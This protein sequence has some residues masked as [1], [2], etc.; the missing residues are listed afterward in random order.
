MQ[1]LDKF[2]NEMNLS[3]KNLYVGHRYVPKIFGEWD[4]TQSYEALSIVQYQGTSY[5]SRQTVPV[6]IEITNEEFWALTGNYNAQIEQYRKDVENVQKNVSDSLNNVSLTLEQ[7]EN[8]INQLMKESIVI[9]VTNPPADLLPY[10]ESETVTEN[11]NRLNKIFDYVKLKTY[12]ESSQGTNLYIGQ[13]YTVYF[14]MTE[15][16]IDNT[17]NVKGSYVA[18]LGNKTIIRT[19]TQEFDVFKT[20]GND[21]WQ[22]TIDDFQFDKTGR[23][24]VQ[25]N[26]NLEGGYTYFTRN[27]LFGTKGEAIKITK[28]SSIGYIA[29]NTFIQPEIVL[30]FDKVDRMYFEKNWIS[31]NRKS[32]SQSAS[33]IARSM[34]LMTSGNLWVPYPVTDAATV[35]ETAYINA[36]CTVM[37]DNDHYGGE[38]GSKTIINVFNNYSNLTDTGG[39]PMLISII[40][41]PNMYPLNEYTA[42]RLF[43]IPNKIEFRNNAG[44]SD[45]S[46][47]IKW[48]ANVNGDELIANLTNPHLFK[49]DIS[50]N[51]GSAFTRL[52][53]KNIMPNN[54][55]KFLVVGSEYSLNYDLMTPRTKSVNNTDKNVTVTN[56]NATNKYLVSF[57][58]SPNA[59]AV[60]RSTYLGIVSFT[61]F[62]DGEYKHRVDITPIIDVAGGT[63]PIPESCNVTVVFSDTD[64]N[65]NASQSN[66]QNIVIKYGDRMVN[67]TFKIKELFDGM[68]L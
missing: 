20:T 32:V 60:Y 45:N 61:A 19:T 68:I 7:V 63:P 16:L 8:N 40:N 9:D 66:K 37:S 44:L 67:G 59:G 54:L 3:G 55:K 12:S 25:D 65:I 46:Y 6:G 36:Y 22:L 23:V 52:Y 31:E 64:E 13:S 62:Y 11:T 42:I 14:P 33:I 2:R 28:Q 15:I 56:V 34:R 5:T 43:S 35:K 27:R 29:F 24:L 39:S 21:G 57:N 4:N 50:G 48:G 18:L 53:T 47:A 58:V 38:A 1:D 41:S 30:D 10:D 51:V 26:T 17:I 49:I